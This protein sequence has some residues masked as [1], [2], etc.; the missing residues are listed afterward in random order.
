MPRPNPS[1]SSRRVL[2]QVS[3]LKS[4]TSK[5]LA[6]EKPTNEQK[7]FSHVTPLILALAD[8]VSTRGYL[9][10]EVIEQVEGEVQRLN[11]VK[12]SKMKHL[13]FKRQNELKEFYRGVHMV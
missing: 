7:K 10:L 6:L 12:A 8:E 5:H 2:V 9:S 3:G 13:M 4:I 11:V 1:W